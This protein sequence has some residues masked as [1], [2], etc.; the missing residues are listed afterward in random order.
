MTEHLHNT[1]TKQAPA[2]VPRST[3]NHLLFTFSQMLGSPSVLLITARIFEAG[4]CIFITVA[5]QSKP[6]K[7]CYQKLAAFR[8]DNNMDRT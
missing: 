7:E 3:E 6:L 5:T 1:T 8:Q 2:L 4:T